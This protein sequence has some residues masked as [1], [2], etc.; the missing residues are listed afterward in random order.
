MTTPRRARRA[1]ATFV[2][3]HGAWHGGW[4]W[5]DVRAGLEARGHRVFTP[6]LTGLADKAHLR[7]PV[8]DLSTHIQDVL[9]VLE[10]E[11]L[12]DVV[13]CGHSYG[14]MV[15][16]GVADRAKSRLRSIV[17]LDAAVPRSGDSMITQGPPRTPEE[18]A[19]VRAGLLSLAP[20]G[21]WMGAF[22]A[23]VLGIPKD[24]PGHAWV[25]RRLTAHPLASWTE[26]L[27]LTN[28][29]SAGLRRMYVLCTD[30]M[31]AGSSFPW[32][33]AQLKKDPSW[34]YRELKTGHDAMVTLPRQTARLLEEAARG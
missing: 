26:P 3:V 25:Q 13:L 15:I 27:T 30:P 28:G 33:G 34:L 2:L 11:E 1:P 22:P 24:H 14:G 6:T 17:Y 32:H 29:G 10:W 4:C 31:M 21:L 9:N 7:E 5:R 18:Q 12:S 8:P 19:A 16:T 23:E 20:D